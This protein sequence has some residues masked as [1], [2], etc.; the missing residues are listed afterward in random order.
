MMVDVVSDTQDQINAQMNQINAQMNTRLIQGVLDTLIYRGPEDVPWD[1]GVVAQAGWRCSLRIRVNTRD[2][3]D[4]RNGGMVR[5]LLVDHLLPIPN[6][7]LDPI[8]AQKFCTALGLSLE[9]CE[10][11]PARRP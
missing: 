4:P 10:T 11:C 1:F 2:S 9:K 6:A 3:D 5:Q 7:P 8:E